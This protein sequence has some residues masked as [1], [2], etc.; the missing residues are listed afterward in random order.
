MNWW[1]LLIVLL[2]LWIKGFFNPKMPS[3][4]QVNKNDEDELLE[5]LGLP[6]TSPK[7]AIPPPTL[8]KK[9]LPELIVVKAPLSPKVLLEKQNIIDVLRSK[10]SAP[11]EMQISPVDEKT[12]LFSQKRKSILSDRHRLREAFIIKEILDKPLAIREIC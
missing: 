11:E 7:P 2:I 4:S 8:P 12:E 5:A 10:E 6:P 9:K 3:T 1:L